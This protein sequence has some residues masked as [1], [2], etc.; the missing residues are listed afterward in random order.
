MLLTL[1]IVTLA[2]VQGYTGSL[3]DE[4]TADLEIGSDIKVYAVEPM[5]SIEVEQAITNISS[6][7]LTVNAVNVP[8]IP[9]TS[10]DGTD[11]N[12]YTNE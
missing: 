4:R 5:T 10:E 3:V 6:K 11:V 12:A 9:L 7:D 8:I 1:S 2:A